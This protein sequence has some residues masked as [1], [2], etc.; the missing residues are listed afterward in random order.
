MYSSL[1]LMTED[2][3]KQHRA[4]VLLLILLMPIVLLQ[5]VGTPSMTRFSHF[6]W[7]LMK[8][9]TC[10][11]LGEPAINEERPR[12]VSHAHDECHCKQLFHS[13]MSTQSQSAETQYKRFSGY[14]AFVTSQ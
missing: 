5:D 11:F 6:S 10:S 14:N 9:Y 3:L 7:A 8:T 4:G 13:G 12:R 1:E 2:V